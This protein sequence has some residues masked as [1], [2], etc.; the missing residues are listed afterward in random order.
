MSLL[1][2]KRVLSTFVGNTETK[3]KSMKPGERIRVMSKN[4]PAENLGVVCFSFATVLT[5]WLFID[6]RPYLTYGSFLKGLKA[7]YRRIQRLIHPDKVPRK[8]KQEAQQLVDSLAKYVKKMED[9]GGRFFDFALI[10]ECI[11][12]KKSKFGQLQDVSSIIPLVLFIFAVKAVFVHRKTIFKKIK[13][14]LSVSRWSAKIRA[15]NKRILRAGP[16]KFTPQV[17]KKWIEAV[18]KEAGR[19]EGSRSRSRSRKHK[20][21]RRSKSRNRIKGVRR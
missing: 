19:G 9:L 4:T 6:G 18:E 20:V 10:H 5:P 15:L 11:S 2:F 13:E 7:K 8:Y 14:F 3:F 17:Q 16:G 12:D 1:A 21:K